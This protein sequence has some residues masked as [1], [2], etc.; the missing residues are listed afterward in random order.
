MCPEI[1]RDIFQLNTNPNPRTTFVIP[2]VKGEFMGK[3][4]LR[5]FGPVVW[6]TM[7]PEKNKGITELEKFKEDIKDW[8]PN[9]KCR[10]CKKYVP[11]LGF[12]ETA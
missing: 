3:L 11:A 8:I 7:L 1:M 2:K 9:C 6:E 10:L 4:S 12:V 5:D